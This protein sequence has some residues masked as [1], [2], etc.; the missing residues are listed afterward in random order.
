MIASSEKF[1]T[2]KKIDQTIAGLWFKIEHQ[3]GKSCGNV[4]TVSWLKKIS[5]KN[6]WK[7]DG[8]LEVKKLI[9]APL[10]GW[11]TEQIQAE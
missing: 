4:D 5:F 1:K 6:V 7:Q 8:I 2:T 3:P 10:D 9:F 11:T